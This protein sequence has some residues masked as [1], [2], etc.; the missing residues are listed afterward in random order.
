MPL[1]DR[2]RDALPLPRNPCDGIW[3]F[4]QSFAVAI[5]TRGVLLHKHV[6]LA[7]GRR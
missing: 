4:M 3:H 5:A 6:P 2:I 7:D 1:G